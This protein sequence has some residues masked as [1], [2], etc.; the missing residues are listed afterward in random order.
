MIAILFVIIGILL[1]L[2][3]HPPNF[4]PITASTLFAGV[5]LPKRY[6]LITPIITMAISDFL[7]FPTHM[8][9]STTLYVWGSFLISGL[10]G[11]WLKR[12]NKPTYIIVASLIASLQFFLITNFGVWVADNMYPHNLNG[13]FQSYL[14][15]IPFYRNTLLGDLFYTSSF[16]SLYRLSLYIAR[17]VS[18]GYV[19]L[20][21]DE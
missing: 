3:P 16:F 19:I 11:S 21:T 18:G 15:G 4:A 5:Y 10:I 8:F 7:L 9:H 6:A 17:K 14:M 20:K 12:H 1:R 13:L 2:V